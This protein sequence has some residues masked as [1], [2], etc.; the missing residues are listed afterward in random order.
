LADITRAGDGLGQIPLFEAII[1]T[2]FSAA[3][4]GAGLA[5]TLGAALARD[6]P[7]QPELAG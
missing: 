1:G 3:V 5:L 6:T 4:L 7:G 2:I